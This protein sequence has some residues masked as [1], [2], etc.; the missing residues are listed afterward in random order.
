[1]RGLDKN[2]ELFKQLKQGELGKILEVIKE[3]K[4]E[5]YLGIRDEYIDIYYMGGRILEIQCVNNNFKFEF[6][7][8]YIPEKYKIEMKDLETK[9]SINNTAALSKWINTL[10]RI[11]YHIANL[12]LGQKDG[13]SAKVKS[14]KIAQQEILINNNFNSEADFF[15]TDMEYSIENINFGRF[16]YIAISKNVDNHGKHKLALIELKYDTRSF[17]GTEIY[18]YGS[19]IVGHVCNFN[20]FVFGEN[21]DGNRVSIFVNKDEKLDTVGQLKRET[22]NIISNYSDL[23]LD[24]VYPEIIKIQGLTETDI[25]DEIETL[26]LV[27]GC[28]NEKGSRVKSVTT[29]LKKYLGVSNEKDAKINVKNTLF[30]EDK[31]NIK[32]KCYIVEDIPKYLKFNFFEELK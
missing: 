9:F 28:K 31:L 1:M 13:E 15:V 22:I 30:K 21:G 4:S 20:R 26:I 2:K 29:S 11:K 5:Y 3:N 8:E 14:E 18:P 23:G 12:Q 27:V 17:E 25:S 24:K 32:L 19:G 16:D 7:F 6:D 10:P